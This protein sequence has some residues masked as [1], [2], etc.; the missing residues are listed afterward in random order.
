MTFLGL[1]LAGAMLILNGTCV[2]F[3]KE[4]GSKLHNTH[5]IGTNRARLSE[6][7]VG[8]PEYIHKMSLV[9]TLIGYNWPV[10]VKMAVIFFNLIILLIWI[11]G[12]IIRPELNEAWGCYSG[13]LSLA[14]LTANTCMENGGRPARCWHVWPLNP[15]AVSCGGSRS[16]G[17]AWTQH[18][19]PLLIV[20]EWVFTAA[21]V[22]RREHVRNI[23]IQR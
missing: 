22:N 12:A 14:Q 20:A 8:Y 19:P 16:A 23:Y 18:V 9:N 3:S 4:S 10:A 5:G 21:I 1:A 11:G 17:G 15:P 6:Q 2:H 13:S 7:D